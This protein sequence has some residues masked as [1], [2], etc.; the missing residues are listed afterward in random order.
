MINLDFIDEKIS[1]Q[2][3]VLLDGATGT[4]LEQ[5]GVAMNSAAWSAEAILTA[6]EIVQAV[7]EDYIRAGADIITSNSFSLAKHMLLRAGLD[8]EFQRLNAASIT[9]ALKA[10]EKVANNPVAIAGSIAPTTFCADP[11]KCYPPLSDA[12]SWYEQQAMILAEAGA[13][14]LIIEMIEDITQ[15]SLAVEAAVKTGLPVWLGLSCRRKTSGELML[16]EFEHTLAEGIEALAPIGGDAIFIMHTETRDAAEAFA[17]LSARWHGKRGVYAH[18]GEFIMPNWQ[19]SN[20]ISP[21]AYASAARQ[22]VEMGAHIIGG[23]CGIGPA[24]IRLLKE[25]LS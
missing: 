14:L 19:F 3:I 10:R 1:R 9:L 21:E 16:W 17:V 11:R 12:F 2:Q 25:V 18:S 24:H 6:P 7:H 20:V 13:D 15:G 5:R 4:E 23:C 22:W 8:A